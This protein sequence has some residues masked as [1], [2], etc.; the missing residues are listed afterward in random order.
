V[1]SMTTIFPGFGNVKYV[2]NRL[3]DDICTDNVSPVISSANVGGVGV[4]TATWPAFNC[5]LDGLSQYITV[6]H[7]DLNSAD[8]ATPTTYYV[9]IE[10]VAGTP[11]AKAAQLT[12]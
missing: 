10:D 11:T 1:I 9:Y 12:Q 2:V 6:G 8:V 7:I 4:V 5:V 3:A